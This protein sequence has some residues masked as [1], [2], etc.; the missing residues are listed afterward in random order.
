MPGPIWV[1]IWRLWAWKRRGGPIEGQALDNGWD[2]PR[3]N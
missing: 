2:D 3:Y 1:G